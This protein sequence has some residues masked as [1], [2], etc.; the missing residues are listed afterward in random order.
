MRLRPPPFAPFNTVTKEVQLCLAEKTRR[1]FHCRTY[2]APCPTQFLLHS[3]VMFSGCVGTVVSVAAS[4][5][6]IQ[7]PD[8]DDV[9]L[10]LRGVATQTQTD[11]RP[12]RVTAALLDFW[13]PIWGRDTPQ[14]SEDI[15]CW[16]H[17]QQLLTQ[18]IPAGRG[19]DLDLTEVSMW[20][21][22]VS[23]LK[24]TAAAGVCGWHNTEL[25]ALPRGALAV[26]ARL[27][28]GLTAPSFPAHLLQAKVAAISKV[29]HPTSAAHAR[30]ITI[31]SCLY[32]LWGRVVCL[33]AIKQWSLVLPRPI[34][35]LSTRPFSG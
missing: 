17:F 28:G 11:C 22:A 3:E 18:M 27:L 31:M 10:P 13:Q 29:A 1:S 32:R 35:G 14:A 20:Q 26:L 5:L 21:H 4:A 19:L 34:I 23:K 33:H 12:Q 15:A 2:E 25:K 30:P 7:F 16:P 9:S 6:T 24:S 8:S